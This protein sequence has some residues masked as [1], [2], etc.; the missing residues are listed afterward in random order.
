VLKDSFR[1]EDIIARYGGDEFSVIIK[2]CNNEA[3]N[4][5]RNR[6]KENT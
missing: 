4:N 5:Y 1:E 2:N 3:V 6:I